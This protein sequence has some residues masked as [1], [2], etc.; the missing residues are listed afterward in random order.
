[1]VCVER[2]LR[3]NLRRVPSWMFPFSFSMAME[4]SVECGDVENE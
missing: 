3:R 4:G 1:M 2:R